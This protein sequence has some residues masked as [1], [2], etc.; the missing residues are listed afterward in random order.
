[1]EADSRR[2][3]A[4]SL[5]MGYAEA[6]WSRWAYLPFFPLR[7]AWSCWGVRL[8]GRSGHPGCREAAVGERADLIP[9]RWIERKGVTGR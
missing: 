4:R 1:M 6:R 2:R 7:S 3:G 9:E 8:F 5:A